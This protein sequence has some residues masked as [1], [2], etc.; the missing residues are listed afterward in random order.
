MKVHSP[1]EVHSMNFYAMS[2]FWTRGAEISL[3]DDQVGGAVT[4][5]DVIKASQTV[6]S[7]PEDKPF[8][9]MDMVFISTLL[10]KGY[11]FEDS[12]SLQIC[13][14]VGKFELS[15]ALGATIDLLH[16]HWDHLAKET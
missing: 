2:Y 7:Q 1:A 14:K 13:P 4:I 12:A 8:L 3:I 5:E 10:T 16:T 11:K 6:C 15:W 9:C